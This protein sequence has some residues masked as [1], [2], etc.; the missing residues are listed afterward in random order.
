MLLPTVDPL[1]ASAMVRSCSGL[2]LIGGGDVDPALYGEVPHPKTCDVD[3]GRDAFEIALAQAALVH[4]I[5]VLGICRGAQVLNVALGGSLRQDLGPDGPP[6]WSGFEPAHDLVLEPD[7]L[8]SV[9]YGS[10]RLKVNSL[11]HQAVGRLGDGLRATGWSHDF[12]IEVIEHASKWA[13]GVQ[14]H[15]ECQ[16]P[17]RQGDEPLLSEFVRQAAMTN[18][19][20]VVPPGVTDR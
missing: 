1:A 3:T 15:P 13:I 20:L 14:W 5:P 10:H 17:V 2:L 11:H 8:V 16:P 18:E 7:S 6:H 19:Y 9:I 12:A 4:D